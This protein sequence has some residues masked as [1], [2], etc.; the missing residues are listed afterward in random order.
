MNDD[1]MEAVLLMVLRWE[2]EMILEEVLRQP[3]NFDV[4]SPSLKLDPEAM[5]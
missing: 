1:V 4:S 3:R 2:L 5:K